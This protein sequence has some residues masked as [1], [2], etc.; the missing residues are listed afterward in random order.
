MRTSAQEYVIRRNGLGCK[1]VVAA[2]DRIKVLMRRVRARYP[3]H[4]W[5]ISQ[6]FIF[7]GSD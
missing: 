4:R 3:G 1:L 7:N 6:R 5:S 2:P